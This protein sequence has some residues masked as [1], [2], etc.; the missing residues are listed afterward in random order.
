LVF[1]KSIFLTILKKG[2]TNVAPFFMHFFIKKL[3]NTL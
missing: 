3:Y 2:A 1:S